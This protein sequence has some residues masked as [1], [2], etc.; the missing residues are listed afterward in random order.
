M[1]RLGWFL[2]EHG[3]A[4]EA[5]ALLREVLEIRQ[6]TMPT[7]WPYFNAKSLLGGALAA[8]GRFDEAEPLLLEA[9]AHMERG[10]LI[11]ASTPPDRI[12]EAIERI[13][14]LYDAWHSAEPNKG[15]DEN[16]A[17]WRTKLVKWQTLTPPATTQPAP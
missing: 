8:Q 3:K 1:A 12:R 15:Y 16:A 13:I 11:P 5:E 4:T 9:F 17:E 6:K 10:P 7:Y 14:E 2:T